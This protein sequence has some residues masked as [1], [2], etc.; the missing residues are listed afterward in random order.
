MAKFD[1]VYFKEENKYVRVDSFIK[2]KH[3]EKTY[4]LECLTT[5]MHIVRKQGIIP[6][7]ASNR[8][9]EHLESCQHY[10]EVIEDKKLVELV[11]SSNF[12]DKERLEFLINSNLEGAL[13]LLIKHK[14]PDLKLKNDSF[15]TNGVIKRNNSFGKYERESILRVSIKIYTG[16]KM[17]C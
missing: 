14:N 13:N 4:C 3:Y 2:K 16:R 8:R 7:F 12:K 1:E 15:L 5:P 17:Y 10:N 11:K 9:Q 6:Y